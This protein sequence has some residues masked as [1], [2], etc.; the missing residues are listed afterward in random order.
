MT[1][2][3][4]H[5]VLVKKEL[6]RILRV[7]RERYQPLKVILYGSTVTGQINEW[8]DIDLV[9]IKNTKRRFYDRIGEVVKLVKPRESLDV[10]VYTPEEYARLTK[11]S[12]FVGE[13]VT[14]KGK[15]IYAV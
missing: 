15:V 6:T 13:E 12:W 11:E 9:V 4:K 7:I 5:E 2:S 8:S 14:K 10:L 1:D 3:K